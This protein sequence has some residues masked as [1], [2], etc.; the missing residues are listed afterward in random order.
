MGAIL[1]PF[2]FCNSSTGLCLCYSVGHSLSDSSRPLFLFP[3]LCGR[4]LQCSFPSLSHNTSFLPL[5]PPLTLPFPYALILLHLSCLSFYPL[6]S[7][8]FFLLSLAILFC[9][10]FFSSPFFR[11]TFP[12]FSLHFAFN[13]CLYSHFLPLFLP[14][15]LF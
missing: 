12:S 11:L 2:F 1:F 13:L 6:L 5:P 9:F 15:L 14:F 10:L 7:L 8:I 3:F 4:P